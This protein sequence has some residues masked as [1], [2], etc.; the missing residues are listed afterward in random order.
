MTD[1]IDPDD[2]EPEDRRAILQRFNRARIEMLAL[3]ERHGLK[4]AVSMTEQ[5]VLYFIM[6]GRR[7]GRSMRRTLLNAQLVIDAEDPPRELGGD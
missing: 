4:L 5:P 1:L 3:A 7:A 2:L 6:G